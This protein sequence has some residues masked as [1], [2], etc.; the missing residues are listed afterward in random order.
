MVV[1]ECAQSSGVGENGTDFVVHVDEILR[2][3]LLHVEPVH[4]VVDGVVE[5]AGHDLRVGL[6]VLRVALKHLT[7]GVDVGCCHETRPEVLLNV[8]DGVDA[9]AVE[10][11]LLYQPADPVAVHLANFRVLSF[12]IWK[13]GNL[14]VLNA[15]LR[16]VVNVA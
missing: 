7:D 11:V 10:L 3:A 4:R 2:G 14:A 6:E 8:L 16:R 13:V 5:E 12:H 15:G 1:E 9:H